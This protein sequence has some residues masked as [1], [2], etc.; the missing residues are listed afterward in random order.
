MFSIVDL[1]VYCTFAMVIGGLALS[2][3]ISA[4]AEEE[5]EKWKRRYYRLKKEMKK[6]EEKGE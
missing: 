1:V 4:D 2:A 5:T 6:L 3:F